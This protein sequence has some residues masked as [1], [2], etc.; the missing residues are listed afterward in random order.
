MEILK[1]DQILA[2]KS[3]WQI[4]LFHDLFEPHAIIKVLDSIKKIYIYFRYIVSDKLKSY[5]EY[6]L[7]SSTLLTNYKHP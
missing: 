5:A 2:D 3:T 6:V 1:T 4:N 7:F